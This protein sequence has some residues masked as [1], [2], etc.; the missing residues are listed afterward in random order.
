MLRRNTLILLAV[1]AVLLIVAILIQR[2]PPPAPEAAPTFPPPPQLLFNIAVE[3]I[4][5]VRLEDDQQNVLELA[6]DADG[7]W[8]LI[9]PPEKE[10]DETKTGPVLN[11]LTALRIV[12]T[13]D[14]ITDL[15]IVG[16]EDPAYTIAV[17]L[18]DGEQL[19][20]DFGVQSPTGSGYYAQTESD[21]LVLVDKYGLELVLGLLENPPIPNT[22]T[23]SPTLET[24]P[25]PSP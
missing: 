23:P 14:E 17:T 6:Q 21:A 5:R 10:V 24:T 16:L 9:E 20:A 11:Q 8:A 15:D 2:A 19:I 12:S 4:T 1:F 25:T 3:D 22:P 18:A 7:N 13:F